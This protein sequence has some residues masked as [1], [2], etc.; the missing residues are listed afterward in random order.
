MNSKTIKKDITFPPWL[1]RDP[2]YI[3]T[4]NNKSYL[5]IDGLKQ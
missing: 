5:I 4:T 3:Y 2:N 1:I